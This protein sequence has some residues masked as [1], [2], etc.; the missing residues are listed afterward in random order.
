MSH[1]VPYGK[2]SMWPPDAMT[3]AEPDGNRGA[4]AADK[5][6]TAV[7]DDNS[8][9]GD[10][11]SDCSE[12][13]GGC[14]CSEVSECSEY[15]ECRGGCEYSEVS[16]NSECSECRGGC[17]NSE[18]SE[19]SEYRVC[20]EFSEF[21]EYSEYSEVSECSEFSESSESSECSALRS[22]CGLWHPPSTCRV[23]RR[24]AACLR[25][26]IISS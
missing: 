23:L 25:F 1:R 15:S 5:A 14:E 3:A 21:S 26:L 18:V 22:C 4:T 7:S 2:A 17:E 12:C 16:E 20:S 6:A 19:Y 13:R 9:R 8:G 11:V 24:E 10:G